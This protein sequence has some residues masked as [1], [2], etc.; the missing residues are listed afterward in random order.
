MR[1]TKWMAVLFLA[2]L[3]STGY[4][5]AADSAQP[6]PANETGKLEKISDAPAATA[7]DNKDCPVHHSK[8]ECPMDHGKKDFKHKHGEPCS[9]HQDEMHGKS[10][11][12]C[13]HEQH[14]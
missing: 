13:D 1:S 6:A 3:L 14:S 12:K 11:E 10:H 9:H 7:Q 8:K 5:M 2:G 4:V